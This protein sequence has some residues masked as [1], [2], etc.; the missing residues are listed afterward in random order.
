MSHF[1]R[2]AYGGAIGCVQ[3]RMARWGCC[4]VA[5]HQRELGARQWAIG[6]SGLPGQMGNQESWLEGVHGGS[7]ADSKLGIG[8]RTT[9][10]SI[11]T[12]LVSPVMREI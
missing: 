11:S 7:I 3:P 4:A 8:G 2:M 12:D 9:M 6:P 10:V 5:W 1:N